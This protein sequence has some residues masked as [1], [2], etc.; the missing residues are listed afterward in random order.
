MA[1]R[2]PTA[3]E[4][5][6]LEKRLEEILADGTSVTL[7]TP[8]EYGQA[9]EAEVRRARRALA[10]RRRARPAHPSAFVHPPSLRARRPRPQIAAF[11]RDEPIFKV[12]D[13]G[14][15]LCR[16]FGHG[17]P[18]EVTA[19]AVRSMR[20]LRGDV[21]ACKRYLQ[22]LA[23]KRALKGYDLL[24]TSF[25]RGACASLWLSAGFLFRPPLHRHVTGGKRP[26]IVF[27]PI[28]L[29][30]AHVLRVPKQQ[31]YACLHYQL[32]RYL[33][34]E[35]EA[36]LAGHVLVFDLAEFGWKH[37]HRRFLTQVVKLIGVLLKNYPE[38][39]HKLCVVN[40]P[41]LFSIAWQAILPWANEHVQSKI[42][43]SRGPNADVLR[44]LVGADVLPADLGGDAPVDSALAAAHEAAAKAAASGWTEVS[45]AAGSTAQHVLEVGE[46]APGGG[47]AEGGPD[48]AQSIAIEFS[49]ESS[50]VSFFV[51]H[52]PL[53]AAGGKKGAEQS[54]V[55][56]PQS[57]QSSGG[58]V[59]QLLEGAKPG[60][61][62]CVWDNTQAWRYPRKVSYRVFSVKAGEGASAMAS[63]GTEWSAEDDSPSGPLPEWE[64][65][66]D[67]E[68]DAMAKLLASS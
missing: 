11:L 43:I 59:S 1:A 65:L 45:I 61:Y 19:M 58:S 14:E 21:P 2:A 13:C 42:A 15:R 8:Q 62:T 63:G 64:G 30:P 28:E 47:A 20:A 26:M 31:L 60:K 7:A 23:A 36:G 66:G 41:S 27:A 17:A 67:A 34:A 35:R 40:A 18:D 25:E 56:E 48:G 6:D 5:A 44:E 10:P 12:A 24:I 38:T 51:V 3:A 57:Y 29:E 54:Y 53:G 37:L 32:E 39:V 50:D 52:E 46:P 9:E 55:L 22:Y 16:A 4:R 49:I 68:M 33:A